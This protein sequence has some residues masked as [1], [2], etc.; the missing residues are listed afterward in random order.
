MTAALTIEPAEADADEVLGLLASYYAEIHAA[1]GY[2]D[3]HASPTTTADF[4]P[5]RGRMFVVRDVDGTA[6]G[7]G[8]VRLLEPHTAEVKRM[9]LHPSMRGRGAGRA[10]LN[11]LEAE[12]L[13]LGATRGVLDTNVTLRNALALY[14]AAGWVEVPP[15]NTNEEATHWF[16]KQLVAT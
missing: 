15:Y 3:S 11:V 10:L 16:E 14:R 7:C 5:P 12:A 8:A 2:D 13:R 9:W 6:R 4:T 1:F